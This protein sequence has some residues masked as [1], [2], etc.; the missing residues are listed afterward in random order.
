MPSQR[1][2]I[3][4]AA[5]STATCVCELK[6]TRES[7]LPAISC[8]TSSAM[9]VVLPVPGGPCTT[10]KSGE[11]RA[12]RTAR[13]FGSS[14]SCMKCVDRHRGEGR[15]SL[16][17]HE[18]FSEIIA[19]AHTVTHIGERLASGAR[20]RAARRCG[21]SA[22]VLCRAA[23][24]CCPRSTASPS[25]PVTDV[26]DGA[27]D[28]VSAGDRNPP[29]LVEVALVDVVADLEDHQS[30]VATPSRERQCV[31]A[32]GLKIGLGLE[33]RAPAIKQL[34]LWIARARLGPARLRRSTA[35]R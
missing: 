15:R 14:S 20:S 34:A 13:C 21:R 25:S 27:D 16:G 4:T 10:V 23:R 19:R 24:R 31:L 17:V 1:P 5:W 26:G 18:Q 8:A 35:H 28:R 9:N 2:A 3:L 22:T 6:R 32:V 7:S 12:A 29:G 11:E 33:D 30:P